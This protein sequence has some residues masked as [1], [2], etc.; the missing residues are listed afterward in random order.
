MYFEAAFGRPQFL[1]AAVEHLRLPALSI[2][3]LRAVA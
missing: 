1:C 3:L 2:A